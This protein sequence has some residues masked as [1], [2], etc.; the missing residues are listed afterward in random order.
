MVTNIDSSAF[1]N[2]TALT[3]I[4][5]TGS[6]ETISFH[7]FENCTNL[8][9]IHIDSTSLKSV[10]SDAFSGTEWE[11]DFESG[12]EDAYFGN[13]FYKCNRNAHSDGTADIKDGTTS[14]SEYAFS[15]CTELKKIRIP[16][17][18]IFAG[19]SA[20]ECCTGLTELT[21]PDGLVETDH[22]V[23]SQCTGLK[24]FVIPD[25]TI[26]IPAGMFEGCSSLE[27]VTIP[28]FVTSIGN[29]AFRQCTFLKSVTI[30]GS[31]KQIGSSSQ[32][33]I[34]WETFP[35]DTI[36]YFAGSEEDYEAL[37]KTVTNEFGE[38]VYDLRLADS[39]ES[40]SAVSAESSSERKESAVSEARSE[41]SPSESVAGRNA[42]VPTTADDVSMQH[43]VFTFAGISLVAV[44]AAAIVLLIVR[45]KQ[46]VK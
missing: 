15:G 4:D 16:E 32:E 39:G 41:N 17:S 21:F 24:S 42:D 25:G 14:I 31:V 46:S 11:I 19:Q 33:D 36:V 18:V 22:L 28:D 5:I 37:K 9:D 12:S 1:E 20:F 30:P 26:Q 35:K 3:H 44:I 2:C 38:T 27:S 40:S 6:I 29:D 43:T 7:A 10:K 34:P 23:L 13:L 8:K 45:K